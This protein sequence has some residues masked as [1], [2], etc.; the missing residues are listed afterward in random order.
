MGIQTKRWK[1]TNTVTTINQYLVLT[2]FNLCFITA[3]TTEDLGLL[4]KTKQITV[5][6]SQTL[7]QVGLLVPLGATYADYEA[8]MTEIKTLTDRILAIPALANTSKYFTTFS[9]PLDTLVNSHTM[10]KTTLQSILRHKND[11]PALTLLPSC[12]TLWRD[13]SPNELKELVAKLSFF[14]ILFI[15]FSVFYSNSI[16]RHK[17]HF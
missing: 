16:T 1:S 4:Q 6:S 13:Y 2:L 10:I 9:G 17:T 15:E 14:L 5:S 12:I 11:K 3:Q 7:Q 8:S